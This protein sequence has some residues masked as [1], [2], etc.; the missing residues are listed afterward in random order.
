MNTVNS[1][2]ILTIYKTALMYEV[3]QIANE[4]LVV[5]NKNQMRRKVVISETKI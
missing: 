2:A 5:Q 1:A 3:S 4:A